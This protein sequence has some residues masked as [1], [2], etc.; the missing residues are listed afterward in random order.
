MSSITK[1]NFK[2]PKLACITSLFNKTISRL[3]FQDELD[4]TRTT[5]IDGRAGRQGKKIGYKLALYSIGIVELI[6]T[7]IIP[8]RASSETFSRQSAKRGDYVKDDSSDPLPPPP[9][10]SP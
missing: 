9:P 6:V 1:G 2:C 8:P 7:N 5:V 4:R 3:C 10:K